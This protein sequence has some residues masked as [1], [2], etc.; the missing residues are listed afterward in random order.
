MSK[1]RLIKIIGISMLCLG[2]FIAGLKSNSKKI[3]I[4][5]YN[6][7]NNEK[8]LIEFSNK[9]FVVI[10]ENKNIYS[11][12]HRDLGDYNISFDTLDELKTFINNYIDINNNL[13]CSLKTLLISID[14]NTLHYIQK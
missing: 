6:Y 4:E 7:I 5:K 8:F 13:W 1:K 9:S 11:F 3:T 2:C 12:Y 10:E 14:T